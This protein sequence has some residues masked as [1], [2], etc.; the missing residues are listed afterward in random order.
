[1]RQLRLGSGLVLVVY[2]AMHLLNHSLALVSSEAL[3]TGRHLFLGLWRHPLGEALLAAAAILHLVAALWGLVGRRSWRMP[4][5]QALQIALGFLI[6]LF[7]TAHV[8][9]TGLLH[10]ASGLEDTYVWVFASTWP[11]GAWQQVLIVVLVWLHGC[12][13]LHYWLRLRSRYRRLFPSLLVL[14]T[15]L[16]V[17]AIL[18]YVEGGRSVVERSAADPAWLP[19]VAQSQNWPSPSWLGWGDAVARWS[20]RAFVAA[21]LLI[22]AFD[23]LRDAVLRRHNRV[24]ITYDGGQT[25]RVPKGLSVLEASRIGGIPHAAV[26]GGR[27]RCSTCRIRVGATAGAQPPPSPG[28]RR[29]LER[30]GAAADVRLACQ[31][32]PTHDLA[33]ARLMPAEATVRGAMRHMEPNQGREREIAVLFADLRGFTRLA[34]SRLPYDVV[35]VLNRYFAAMGA[36]IEAQGGRVDKFIGDGIMALFGID[37]GPRQ[38]A[39][40]ALAAVGAMAEALAELNE[41]LKTELRE[42][43]RMGIGLHAG[44]AIVGEMGWGRATSLTAVGDTVNTASRLETLT[45]ELGAQL[46]VSA[47]VLELADTSLAP[48]DGAPA[49]EP[50]EVD[51]RGRDGR[52]VVWLLQDARPLAPEDTGRGHLAGGWRWLA[53]RATERRAA[54][55]RQAGSEA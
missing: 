18:G 6:P 52:L 31:L 44:P 45:K 37:G 19:A 29:V 50:L 53:A 35:F 3:A 25:V 43:L 34:E 27:G 16:P 47:H 5:W 10:R 55:A 17:L 40:Q 48:G 12:L 21:V 46:V 30:I 13:G 41:D 24:R 28:E 49:A 9:G 38:G 4:A 1:M 15:L 26:C 2:A 33:V 8:V 36:A 20:V 39:R 42:P 7:L 22:L 54:A 11:A 23:L 51:V 14:A 32:R